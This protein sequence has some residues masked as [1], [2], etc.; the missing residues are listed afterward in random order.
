MVNEVETDDEKAG[1]RPPHKPTEETKAKVESLSSYGVPEKSI[2]RLIGLGSKNTLRK[3]YV[4]ELETGNAKFQAMLGQTAARVALGSAAEYFPVG[5]PNAGKLAK[6]EV[7][8]NT[9]MLIFFLKTRL[10]L[11]ERVSLDVEDRR[12]DDGNEFN[13]VGLTQ[14]ERTARIVA[15]LKTA[16]SRKKKTAPTPPIAAAKPED[17]KLN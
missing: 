6:A 12:P 2:A 16:E 14:A 15:L 3:H 8:P 4:I 7:L 9:S 5:H 10:G 1:H 11:Q 17:R 13:T